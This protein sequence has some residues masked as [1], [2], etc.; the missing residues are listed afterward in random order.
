M[1]TNYSILR[2]NLLDYIRRGI[3]DPHAQFELSSLRSFFR[4]RDIELDADVH[5]WRKVKQI[6]H[7]FY[8]EGILMP[9]QITTP[10]LV[11]QTSFLTFPF[12]H[13]TEYGEKVLSNPEYQPHDPEGYLSRIKTEIPEI[14]KVIIRYLEEGLTCFRRNLLFAAAVMLGCAAEKAILLLVETFGNS[15]TNAQQKQEYEKET[16]IFIISR[17]WKALWK[18]LE[19]LS[20]SLPDNLGDDLGTILERTFDIIRTT[21]NEAGHP[22]GK[23]IEKETVHANL[24]LFPIFCRRIYGLIWYFS[25]Q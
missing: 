6:I 25:S 7:E 22:T 16:K 4:D 13:V 3:T 9:G 24:L 15:L 14:D 1:A 21:R 11:S 18:R 19:P 17:K 5:D 23:E 8:I 10:N 2:A 12:F 20:S